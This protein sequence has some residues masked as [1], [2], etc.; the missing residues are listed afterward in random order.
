MMKN[1]NTD[2]LIKFI[3]DYYLEKE[4]TEV[5]ASFDENDKIFITFVNDLKQREIPISSSELRFMRSAMYK[6][7]KEVSYCY[8]MH[9]V[10]PK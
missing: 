7:N 8:S 2:Y 4:N 1:K 3:E 10:S 5:I 9:K 6:P